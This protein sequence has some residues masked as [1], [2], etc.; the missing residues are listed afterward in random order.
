MKNRRSFLKKVA[1]G[2]TLAGLIPLSKNSMAGEV[3]ISEH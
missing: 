3:K 1:A 2:L